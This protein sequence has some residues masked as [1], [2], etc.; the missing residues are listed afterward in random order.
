[1]VSAMCCY[2]LAYYPAEFLGASMT[3]ELTQAT[4]DIKGFIK[5]ANKLG[6]NILP[7]D[8][9]ISTNEFYANKEG[10]R[11]PLNMISF[12][13]DACYETILKNKP[14]TSFSDFI[15]RNPKSKVKKNAVLNLIKAGCFDTFNKNRSILLSDFY[16]SRNEDVEVFYW[17]DEVQM[18]YE[19]EL[20][21]FTLN[22]HPLDGYINKDIS[23]YKENDQI[24]II[25][26]VNEIKIHKDKHKKDMAFLKLE[27][28]ECDF[29]GIVFSYA[30]PKLSKAI[31]VGA[32]LGLQG[33]K[34]GNT[35]L[36]NNAW[37]I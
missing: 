2:F 36:I 19:K 32:K 31:Y 3:L 17:C 27:N 25:C 12:I 28:K 18:I 34:Q 4:P 23:E 21:G 5:E 6:I 20:F 13:G 35:I 30:Y 9:N 26:I 15:T 22:K 37:N 14:Y 24:N 11:L 10:I 29:E 1:M 16:N 7:P 33:K 8:I